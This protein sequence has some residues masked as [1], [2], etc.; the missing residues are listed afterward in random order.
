MTNMIYEKMTLNIIYNKIKYNQMTLNLNIITWNINGLRA[1][2]QKKGEGFMGFFN[3]FNKA[4]FDILCF[5]EQKCDIG[6]LLTSDNTLKELSEYSHIAYTTETEKK[7]YAGA[8]IFSKIPFEFVQVGLGIDIHDKNGRIVTVKLEAHDIVLINVYVPNSGEGLKN[9]DYRIHQ[10]DDD[11]KLHLQ[12]MEDKF[13]QC[14][15][16]LCGDMNAAHNENDVYDS[17]RFKNKVAGFHDEE[18]YF[19][20]ELI[21]NDY[22]DVYKAYNPTVENYEHFTFWSNMG[23][24]RAKNKGWRIDYFFVKHGHCC[25]KWDNIKNLQYVTGSDHCPLTLRLI[26]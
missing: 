13:P 23:G 20:T 24:M 5:Q 12:K 2:L 25:V 17:L 16:V 11:F 26:I 8:S 22:I 19:I 4:K 10:W 21:K 14:A 15:I 9:L 3:D 1:K 6:K 18:R 7:G